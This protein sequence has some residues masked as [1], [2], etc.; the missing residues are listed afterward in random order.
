[1]LGRCGRDQD[2]LGRLLNDAGG[3]ERLTDAAAKIQRRDGVRRAAGLIEQTGQ[4]TGD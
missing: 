1:V 2:A 3:H 4:I